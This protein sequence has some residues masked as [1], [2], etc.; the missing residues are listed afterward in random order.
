MEV[1]IQKKGNCVS[2]YNTL[3]YKEYRNIINNP[4]KSKRR[5]TE[6]RRELSVCVCV[7]VC[8]CVGVCV[9]VC[10]CVCWC[11]CVCIGVSFEQKQAV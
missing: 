5:F 9:C 11:V 6:F 4:C 3:T 2:Q 7:W 8:W 10:V 1:E